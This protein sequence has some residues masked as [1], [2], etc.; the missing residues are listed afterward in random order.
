MHRSILTIPIVIVFARNK[1]K[2]VNTSTGNANSYLWNF[3]D[4]NTSTQV[5]PNKGYA[6]TGFLLLH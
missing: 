4:G 2:F 5:N 6:S 3:G 1:I